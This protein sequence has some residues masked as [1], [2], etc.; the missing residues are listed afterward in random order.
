M[1][2]RLAV[3]SWGIPRDVRGT[4]VILTTSCLGIMSYL[5][6]TLFLYE[7]LCTYLITVFVFY[8]TLYD[9]YMELSFTTR[10]VLT[11]VTNSFAFHRIC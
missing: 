9:L 6:G 7:I 11:F 5:P 1:C 10:I 3:S 2:T 8:H 4:S